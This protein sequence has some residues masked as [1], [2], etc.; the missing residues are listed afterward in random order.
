MKYADRE[1]NR[2]DIQSGQDRLLHFLYA[3]KGTR[4]LLCLLASPAVSKLGGR[5]LD[6]GFSRIFVKPFIWKHNIDLSEYQKQKF[7][8]YNDFFT[9]QIRREKRPMEKNSAALVSPCDG[10]VSV[11]PITNKLRLTIKGRTYALPTLLKSQSAARRYAGG[12]AIVLR[13]TVDDYHRYCYPASGEKSGQRTIPGVLYTVNPAAHPTT[14]VYHEN[15][16]E[17]CLIR[18]HSFGVLL[19]MEVGALLVGKI[20]N[21]HRAGPVF[22]GQE[23]GYFAFGGSTILLL[24]QKDQ[25][26]IDTDLLKNTT[27]GYETIVKMGMQL[28]VSK[29]FAVSDGKDAVSSKSC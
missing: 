22:R 1:G 13:L 21:Y 14:A 16:R 10:K 9:R 2:T 4:R 20:Q 3:A 28:G 23:K 29:Q 11:Y 7:T 15:S 27:E 19:M 18:T 17:Y 25:V 6:S 24:V 26:E 12:Y 8:S 5:I